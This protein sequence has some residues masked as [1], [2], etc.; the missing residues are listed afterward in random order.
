MAYRMAL[1]TTLLPLAMWGCAASTPPATRAASSGTPSIASAGRIALKQDAASVA[2]TI[3]GKPFTTYRFAED[4]SD[5]QWQHPYFWPVL[6][7]ATFRHLIILHTG[8]AAAAHVD[9]KAQAWRAGQ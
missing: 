5:P 3:D 8:D 7:N 4:P 2:I 6:L 1:L 9:E